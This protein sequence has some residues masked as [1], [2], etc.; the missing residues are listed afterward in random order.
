MNAELKG[1]YSTDVDDVLNFMP[2]NEEEFSFSL[3]LLVG[4]KGMDGEE[5]FEVEVCTPKWILREYDRSEVVMGR[6][7][8]I[9]AKYDFERLMGFIEKYISSCTGDNW[10][11][12][13]GK[14]SR[15]GRW[16]FEDYIDKHI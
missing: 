13:A 7:R 12:V 2:L 10:E 8:L 6:H 11:E 5:S 15:L 1:F 16:E 4:P 9:M 14:L 3:Q